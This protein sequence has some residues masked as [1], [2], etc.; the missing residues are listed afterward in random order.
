MSTSG[1]EHE[2]SSE[3][4]ERMFIYRARNAGR[5]PGESI[6]D[7]KKRLWNEFEYEVVGLINK[8]KRLAEGIDVFG[9]VE[10]R[11]KSAEEYNCELGRFVASDFKRT[12]ILRELLGYTH[13]N[14]WLVQKEL[15]FF[16]RKRKAFCTGRATL[17]RTHP[18]RIKEEAAAKGYGVVPKFILDYHQAGKGM[19]IPMDE[20]C[21]HWPT[22]FQQIEKFWQ[23]SYIKEFKEIFSKQHF[24]TPSWEE[25]LTPVSRSILAR[26][27]VFLKK[28]LGLKDIAEY[29]PEIEYSDNPFIMVNRYIKALGWEPA[30]VVIKPV[31]SLTESRR[32][33]SRPKR[34]IGVISP[35]NSVASEEEDSKEEG[36][37]RTK[38]KGWSVAK[39]ST[40]NVTKGRVLA[41]IDEEEKHRKQVERNKIFHLKLVQ[42]KALEKKEQEGLQLPYPEQVELWKYRWYLARDDD[43]MA[44]RKKAMEFHRLYLAFKKKWM[45]SKEA[46]KSRLNERERAISILTATEEVFD[47]DP[48]IEL[49]EDSHSTTNSLTDSDD[50]KNKTR[51]LRGS[52]KLSKSFDGD[53]GKSKKV[54]LKESANTSKD[55]KEAVEVIEVGQSKPIN[56][57]KNQ[58]KVIELSQEEICN[59]DKDKG[60]VVESTPR[61]LVDIEKDK[62]KA[63]ESF[64]KESIN[65][66]KDKEE[67]ERSSLRE[68]VSTEKDKVEFRQSVPSVIPNTEADK[69]E[70]SKSIPRD[71]P[72]EEVE[73]GN[74]ENKEVHDKVIDQPEVQEKMPGEEI[75]DSAKEKEKRPNVNPLPIQPPSKKVR[76]DVSAESSTPRKLT[77][78]ERRKYIASINRKLKPF[79]G[80]VTNDF[81]PPERLKE[82]NMWKEAEDEKTAKEKGM[83]LVYMP[84][85]GRKLIIPPKF[86]YGGHS[87]S[88]T[89]AAI[90]RTYD[91]FD[92]MAL[93]EWARK[94][95]KDSPKEKPARRSSSL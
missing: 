33:S 65:I 35:A 86:P 1:S 53:K 77:A 13:L 17:V 59:I 46:E 39:P 18:C 28:E 85:L 68:S 72:N 64:S 75:P 36:R 58:E 54:S 50:E 38:R 26:P 8:N 22:P 71:L 45:K 84:S 14:S 40:R 9:T 11:I 32:S 42:G 6:E 52:A 24:G 60:E 56:T 3:R 5:K 41:S 49:S 92:V 80:R 66:E 95:F 7:Y 87:S 27:S 79:G 16:Y 81:P 48:T 30:R 90:N 4:G 43:Y 31:V 94:G 78:E 51:P 63:I 67:V 2:K 37:E 82:M 83:N 47:T 19:S 12:K 93:N 74:D 34:S 21:R 76:E 69:G 10:E 15:L 44:A 62:G 70:A 89:S 20:F 88:F 55:Q 25:F 29:E 23:E 91:A 61:E 73:V 57:N